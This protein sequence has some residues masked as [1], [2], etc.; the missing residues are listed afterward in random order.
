MSTTGITH[1]A[2]PRPQHRDHGAHRRR[3]DDDDRAHPLLHRAHPQAGRG[4]RG[5]RDDGL[6]GAGAGAR[7]HDHVGG[8]DGRV[9]RPSDQHY[10]YARARGLY[11]RGRALPAR[12]RRRG[13]RLRLRRRR[14][15]AVR[16]RVAPGRP[17]RRAAHLVHQQDGPHRRR[18]LRRRAVDA[19][20]PRRERGR[21]CRSRSARRS[22]TAASSISSR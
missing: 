22:I 2:G 5:R 15:A 3:Q 17:L 18:L 16:D 20:P 6:D 12:A 9:A 14:A 10:R 1:R 21:A 11:G 4:A 19:R 8:D 7:H 13:R